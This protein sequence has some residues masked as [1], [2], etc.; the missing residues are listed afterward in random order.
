MSVPELRFAIASELL[1]PVLDCFTEVRL[2]G[3]L[4]C[5]K[6]GITCAVTDNN[7][8][9]HVFSCELQLG[10]SIFEDYELQRGLD[11]SD[12]V[13]FIPLDFPTLFRLLRCD[14]SI[15]LLVDVV[16]KETTLAHVL[17]WTATNPEL[18]P[19]NLNHSKYYIS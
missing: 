14:K 6:D 13:H 4:I 10:L 3:I 19:T 11:G 5:T 15:S 7:V 18:V 12:S 9:V 17:P 16:S 8:T 2:L 1:R